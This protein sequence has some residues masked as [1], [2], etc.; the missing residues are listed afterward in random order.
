M[1]CFLVCANTYFLFCFPAAE[2]TQRINFFYGKIFYVVKHISCQE[3]AYD[4]QGVLNCLIFNL[5]GCGIWQ[6]CL[7]CQART[8]HL[9]I[10]AS[11]TIM[12]F[13]PIHVISIDLRTEGYKVDYSF[14]SHHIAT[15][16]QAI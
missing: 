3:K 16:F 4:A 7:I 11:Q 8:E 13:C 2:F 15:G 1:F 5:I 14:N 10:S 6:P 9:P 12:M